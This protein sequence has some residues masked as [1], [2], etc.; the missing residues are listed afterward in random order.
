MLRQR[1]LV[2]PSFAFQWKYSWCEAFPRGWYWPTLGGR[3]LKWQTCLHLCNF[4]SGTQLQQ[5]WPKP[6]LPEGYVLSFLRWDP[7]WASSKGWWMDEARTGVF[8]RD[9]PKIQ[10][11]SYNSQSPPHSQPEHPLPAWSLSRSEPIKHHAHADAFTETTIKET[12]QIFGSKSI[13]MVC[14]FQ[15]SYDAMAINNSQE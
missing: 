8:G 7:Q 9:F 5:T 10:T 12:I 6:E 14:C 2:E 15:H 11:V 13:E 1:G 3:A 4:M